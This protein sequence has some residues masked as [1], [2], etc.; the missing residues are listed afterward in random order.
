MKRFRALLILLFVAAPAA[1][2]DMP[3]SQVLLDGEGWKPLA[4]GFKAIQGLAADKEGNVYV[5]DA[6][7]KHIS[8]VDKSGQVTEFVET[9]LGT[10]GLAMGGNLIYACLAEG[11][12][13]VAYDGKGQPLWGKTG[14]PA[15]DLVV[16]KNGTVY[17]TSS[18]DQGVYLTTADGKERKVGAG[19]STATGLVLWPDQGTLV[20]GDAD[21]KCLWTF[22]VDPDGSLVH[23]DRYYAL[24]VP[25]GE[26]ASGTAG[27]T[28]DTAGRVYAATKKGVQVFD[29]TGRLSGVIL[30]PAARDLSALTFGGPDRDIL[31]VACG[32]TVYARKTKA[33]GIMPG[34]KPKP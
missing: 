22:R 30:K 14:S 28:V 34:D 26:K 32:D 17:Y 3:L 11:K 21:D 18:K 1:A 10:R 15:R 6:E 23:R 33:K 13:I 7:A 16:T 8:K 9:G 29:P 27:M 19:I 5:A 24:F 31:Y 2:Q 25:R 12:G 4:K 20:V